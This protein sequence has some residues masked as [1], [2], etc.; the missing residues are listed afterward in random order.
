[1]ATFYNP[2]TGQNEEVVLSA[3]EIAGI[4]EADSFQVPPVY[5]A[6]PGGE[7]SPGNNNALTM[8]PIKL[9][10][11]F[12]SLPDP[13]NTNTG[14][15]FS[16]TYEQSDQATY[17]VQ[18]GDT[19]S[20]I[21]ADNN[22]SVDELM[23]ANGITNPDY[24]ESGWVLDVGSN[25]GSDPTQT[26]SDGGGDTPTD[27]GG[28]DPS[29]AVS[30]ETPSDNQDTSSNDG[31]DTSTETSTDTGSV[32]TVDDPS[33]YGQASHGNHIIN[34]QSPVATAPPVGGEDPIATPPHIILPIGGSDDNDDDDASAVGGHQEH[35]D[36]GHHHGHHDHGHHHGHGGDDSDNEA[37]AAQ[38][39]GSQQDQHSG[40]GHHGGY[41]G[42][43]SAQSGATD[44]V[45]QSD[46]S[47]MNGT[48]AAQDTSTSE[49]S[50]NQNT[51]YGA[52]STDQ[53]SASTPVDTVTV[54]AESD[55]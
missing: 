23:S 47:W 51:S 11:S 41:G 20:K 4:K 52:D 49:T 25:S 35:S 6:N 26:S 46:T 39:V 2:A 38:A 45:A 34:E 30:A 13:T 1:M 24:I 44:T 9:N 5:N 21:A 33:S 32:V 7:Q 19:L 17:T 27:T 12:S 15:G 54:A 3:Q 36:H 28:E 42:Q 8:N 14:G 48:G 50:Q 40:H 18:S 22:M 43:D 37:G 16:G 53:S 29:A 31:G 10:E 55:S